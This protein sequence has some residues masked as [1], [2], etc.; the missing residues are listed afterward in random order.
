M[1]QKRIDIVTG[2]DGLIYFWQNSTFS[3]INREFRREIV[4]FA[5]E[6]HER[7]GKILNKVCETG[8]ADSETS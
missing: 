7:I 5:R 6:H 8:S 4:K 2:R 1:L 3:S